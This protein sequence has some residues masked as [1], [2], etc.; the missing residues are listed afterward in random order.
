M[1]DRDG[2]SFCLLFISQALTMGSAG[3]K[4]SM[5]LAS[6]AGKGTQVL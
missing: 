4:H 3:I 5:K 2:R 1:K 6:E